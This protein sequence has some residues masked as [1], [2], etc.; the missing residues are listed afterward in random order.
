[1]TTEELINELNTCL[2]TAAQDR[3]EFR[4]GLAHLAKQFEAEKKNR[5]K[6]L[7]KESCKAK[8]KSLKKDLRR[9]ERVFL[10]V[11]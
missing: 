1:M 8:R 9:A 11:M 10:K 5:L 6:M 7:K 3:K 2:G 4:D